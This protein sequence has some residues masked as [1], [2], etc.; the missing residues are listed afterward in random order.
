VLF[1]LGLLASWPAGWLLLDPDL[2][3]VILQ[4]LLVVLDPVEPV[5]ER[6]RVSSVGSST[7]WLC[8]QLERG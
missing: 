1:H 3:G 7:V 8:V 4:A 2:L 5:A 6:P